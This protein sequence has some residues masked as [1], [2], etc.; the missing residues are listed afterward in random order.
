MELTLPLCDN[1]TIFK[2]KATDL[3]DQSCLL[4]NEQV[5]RSMKHLQVLL[6]KRANG[7]KSPPRL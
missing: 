3:V 6:L 2:Q 4:A 7:D 1:H 5:A